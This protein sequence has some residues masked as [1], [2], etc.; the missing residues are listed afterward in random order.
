MPRGDSGAKRAVKKSE[1]STSGRVKEQRR[2]TT[3]A[4][5]W[6]EGFD[7]GLAHPDSWDSPGAL[8]PN[9]YEDEA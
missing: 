5:A 3:L 4:E 1:S 6:Q 8:E 7:R 9:P 2:A